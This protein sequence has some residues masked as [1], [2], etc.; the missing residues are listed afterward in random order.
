MTE[1]SGT[2]HTSKYFC[3]I[4]LQEGIGVRFVGRPILGT[5]VFHKSTVRILSRSKD[6]R[7]F[8]SRTTWR[9]HLDVFHTQSC[10]LT[11]DQEAKA[12]CETSLSIDRLQRNQF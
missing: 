1:R 3:R 12:N 6:R 9:Y 11:T 7:G 4:P 10:S 5:Y 8:L 2:Q